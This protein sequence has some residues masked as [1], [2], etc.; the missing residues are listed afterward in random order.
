MTKLLLPLRLLGFFLVGVGVCL[1][2]RKPFAALW[3]IAVHL[4]TTRTGLRV[5]SAWNEAMANMAE[6][7]QRQREAA[8]RVAS[9]SA[10]K[11]PRR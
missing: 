4:R 5:F 10:G 2:D 7:Q 1:A 9:K 6:Q 3:L 8:E 11:G